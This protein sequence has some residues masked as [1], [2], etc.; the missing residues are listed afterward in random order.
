MSSAFD[1]GPPLSAAAAVL[2]I[3]LRALAD[4]WRLLAKRVAPAE[5]ASV[6]KA[7]AYG[8]GLEPAAHALL[9]AGCRTFFVAQVEEGARARAALGES[10]VIFVLNGLQ[11]GA[12]PS[13]YIRLGLSPV[14]GSAGELE[15]WA[16][17]IGD[18]NAPS[19]AIHIDTGMSRLGFASAV[20]AKAALARRGAERIG[21]GLAMSHF[22][23][24]EE[25]DN[26][27]NALQIERFEKT[28]ALFPGVP[29]SLAN[30]SGIFL[31]QSANYDL[32]RPGYA[33]YGGNPTP[34]A[35]NPMKTVVKLE[36][37]IQ[38]IN[39]IAPR[40]SVG[41]NS[42][43]QAERPTRLAT[44][45]I[46]YADGL[47]RGAGATS[48]RAGAEVIIAG[49]RCPLVGRISMDLCVADVTELPDGHARAGDFA[50]VLG[51]EIGVD[52]FGAR[53]GVIG[54]NVLTGLGARYR[55]TYIEER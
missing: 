44:L 10:P 9:A 15:R 27:W 23:A 17:V 52:E 28:R 40:A 22:V 31:A 45:L 54:Y 12:D 13:D 33:L 8:V 50:E 51:L 55:R 20:E 35:A 14:I 43:W 39:S 25:P 6:I 4:N 1:K 32:A 47:P 7:N 36:A 16:R 37:R 29:A 42:E 24:S 21:V 2:T 49:R 46:G 48:R 5:C 34:F 53:S 41:Y 3:D 26:P 18:R 30:S 19:C 11:A 38:Q